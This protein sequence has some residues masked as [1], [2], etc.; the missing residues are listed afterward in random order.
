MATEKLKVEYLVYDQRANPVEGTAEALILAC[1]RSLKEA[2]RD[3]LESGMPCHIW[4]Y[5]VDES[6]NPPALINQRYVESR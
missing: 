2:R 4:A 5:D 3:A 6:Q 1:A